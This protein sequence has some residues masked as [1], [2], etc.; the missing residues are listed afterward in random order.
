MQKALVSPEKHFDTIAKEY[1]YWKKKNWYYY[2]NL[3]LLYRSLIPAQSRIWEIGCG[4]G[5]ILAS[6]NPSHG[7]GIDISR[8]M[9]KIAI[10]KY[11]DRN[12]L[13]FEAKSIF[14]VERVPFDFIVIADV[15]EHIENVDYFFDSLKRKLPQKAKIIISVAN[16]LW[17][18]A[19]SLG[20]RLKMK[21]PEGHHLR[22][23]QQ[24]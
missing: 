1:D 2:K 11:Q 12:N 18:P 23:N 8:E 16:P 14:Q 20:E 22:L 13:K 17:K 21:M 4:T 6:L 15:V 9:I 7:Y 24:N 3:K 5:D 10:K 19:L